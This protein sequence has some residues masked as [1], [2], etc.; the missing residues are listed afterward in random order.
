MELWIG[1]IILCG[2]FYSTSDFTVS[3]Y[4]FSEVTGD[5][6]SDGF[7]IKLDE[8]GNIEYANQYAGDGYD[9]VSTVCQATTRS[10]LYRRF[11]NF[12]FID[13]NRNYFIRF[14]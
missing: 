5:Y 6:T 9:N 8:D 4:T 10:I 13:K 2:W 14:R 3:D 11:Y 12:N 1:G 7:V